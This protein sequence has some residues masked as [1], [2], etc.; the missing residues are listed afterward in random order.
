ML[1]L[2]EYEPVRSVKLKKNLKKMDFMSFLMT[3]CSFTSV[4]S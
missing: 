4:L 2:I 3:I 1:D